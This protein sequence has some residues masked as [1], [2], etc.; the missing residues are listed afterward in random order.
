[1]T[2]DQDMIKWMQDH[3]NAYLETDGHEGH[4][5]DYTKVGLGYNYTPTLLLKT[6]GRKSG[7]ELISPLIYV[8]WKQDFV[9]VSS[10]NGAPNNPAWYFN[11]QANPVVRFQAGCEKFEAVASDA[12]EPERAKIWEYLVVMFPSF[13]MLQAR[14]DR[15]YPIVLLTPTKKIDRL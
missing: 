5:V 7:K 13:P 10:N 15:L 8:R 3:L 6:I 9:I 14:T 1:M 11:M 2:E 4:M 12:Q